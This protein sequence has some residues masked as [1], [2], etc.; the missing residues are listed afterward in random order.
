MLTG[1]GSG[2]FYGLYTIF[3][4]FA[5]KKYDTLTVNAYTFIFGLI[6]SAAVGKP[7]QTVR[8][9]SA[10]PELLLWCAGI[11]IFCT[12]LPYFFYTK[13]LEGLDS[14]RAAII[15]AV[16]PL[17]GS[18]LGMAVYHEPHTPLKIAGIALIL[19]AIVLLNLPGKKRETENGL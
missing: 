14:G 12:I 2:L 17:V 13:G 4:R 8:V 15:V 7:V 10:E 19:T 16:E 5:L 18:L 1:L 6:G 11:G 3:G 9:I